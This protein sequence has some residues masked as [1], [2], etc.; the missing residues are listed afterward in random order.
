MDL[1][2]PESKPIEEQNYLE[3]FRRLR[4]DLQHV[5]GT[6][7]LSM[8]QQ[9]MGFALDAD[10]VQRPLGAFVAFL[11]ERSRAILERPPSLQELPALVRDDAVRRDVASSYLALSADLEI[12]KKSD[13]QLL[14]VMKYPE[15]LMA[16]FKV[17]LIFALL[18]SLPLILYEMWKFVG[19]GLYEQEQRYVLI[20]LPFSIAFFLLGALFGY[21]W[22]VPIGLQ[23]LASWGSEYAEISFTLESY[24]G[25]FFTLTI[26]LGLVFQT[27]LVMLFLHRIGI[28]S[29]SG[30][31]AARKYTLLGALVFSIIVTPPDP[32]SWFFVTA[33]IMLLYELGIQIAKRLER[34]KSRAASSEAPASS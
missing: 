6:I 14:K 5:M 29:A 34:R 18:I 33:P 25:L 13:A 16:Y 19:A 32:L 23:F 17:A 24:I 31:A 8:M 28:V 7:N 22:M 1:F 21:W 3:R 10:T 27:P 4:E 30:F 11:E 9:V 12:L 2:S 26:V 20:F 15:A